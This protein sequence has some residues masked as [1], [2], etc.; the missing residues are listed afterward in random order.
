MLE[1]SS[2]LFV[3]RLCTF[4]VAN[5]ITIKETMINSR[6]LEVRNLRCRRSSMRPNR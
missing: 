1:S 6:R 2:M 4:T 3:R 5:S